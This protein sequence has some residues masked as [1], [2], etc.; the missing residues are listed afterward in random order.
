MKTR[1]IKCF[2]FIVILILPIL[3]VDYYVD[4]YAS[5]RVTYN[6][7]AKDTIDINYCLG[8]DI[9]L[10][11]RKIKWAKMNNL[12]KVDYIVLGSSLSM[13]FSGENLGIDSFY[14][15]GVSGGSTVNDYLAEVYILYIQD[16]L[17]SHMLI[18][19]SP[20]IFN[21][22]NGDERYLE[23]G[24]SSEYMRD[25]MAG[26]DGKPKDDSFLLGVQIRDLIMPEYFKYN[27]EMLQESKRT[28]YELTDNHENDELSTWLTDGSYVYS[29]RFATKNDEVAIQNSI[30]SI[31]ESNTIYHCSDYREMDEGLIN[32]FEQLIL[33][34]TSNN[35]EVSL[36]L[37]PYSAQMYAY[38]TK[39]DCYKPI[40][41][42]E[43]WAIAYGNDN[44]L[45][46]YGSYDPA[47]IGLELKDLYDAYHV[48]DYFQKSTLWT[49]IET[50]NNEWKK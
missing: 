46:V 7:I 50:A 33:F 23:F 48:R 19:V 16:K 34:L 25:V 47:T 38:I 12:E 35:V 28:Y 42:V 11:E 1:I 32:D 37:P 3:A 20:S 14:N 44:H 30:E 40:L 4:A 9:P 22:N 17:P 39:T 2:V 49:R 31:C 41:E 45:Q 24:N 15:L 10:S 13:L 27:F 29:R 6:R 26:V 36:Y 18:E 21:R 43:E 5:F 8:Q